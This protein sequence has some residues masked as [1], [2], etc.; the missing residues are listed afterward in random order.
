MTPAHAVIA[1]II[2]GITEFFPISSSGHLVVLHRLFGVR[3]PLVAFDIVLHGGTLMSVLIFFRGDLLQILTAER[4]KGIFVI[5]GSIP[6]AVV[7]YFFKDAIEGLFAA[8]KAVGAMLIVTGAW[9]AAAELSVRSRCRGDKGSRGEPLT[10]WRALCVGA[11]QCVAVIPG[12]SRSGSTIGAGLIAGLKKREAFSFS[13]LL[14][15]PAIF[16]AIVLKMR[17]IESRFSGGESAVYAL[18]GFAAMIVGLVSLKILSGVIEKNKLY[19]FAI[20]CVLA[21]TTVLVL[22]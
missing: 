7:G 16:G 8:S 14:S 5:L 11:A 6:V 20:Y 10:W 13:F 12:I 3:E 4:K 17:G 9:L 18:G 1:G 22:L 21:G 19:L 2:Q 15:V